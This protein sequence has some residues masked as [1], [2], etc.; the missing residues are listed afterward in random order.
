MYGSPTIQ[1]AVI[2]ASYTIMWCDI[3]QV[4]F[5]VIAREIYNF[6][7]WIFKKISLGF[8]IIFFEIFQFQSFS[9]VSEAGEGEGNDRERKIRRLCGS[10]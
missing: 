1:N 2:S 7:V 3:G 10:L 5:K 8:R 6:L 9:A 4:S